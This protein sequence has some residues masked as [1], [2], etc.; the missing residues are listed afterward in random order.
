ME[1]AHE[2]QVSSVGVGLALDRPAS[3][4]FEVHRVGRGED[5]EGAAGFGDV[6]VQG[7]ALIHHHASERS[8]NLRPAAPRAHASRWG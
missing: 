6:A 4:P 7:Q 3:R 2:A 1:L 8:Q 5:A